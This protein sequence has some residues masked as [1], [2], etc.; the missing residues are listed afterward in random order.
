MIN[1]DVL[2]FFICPPFLSLFKSAHF[3]NAPLLYQL[4]STS[5]LFSL[6]LIFNE[7]SCRR[8]TGGVSS[9]NTDIRQKS[10]QFSLHLD[11][12]LSRGV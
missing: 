5:I 2:V 4:N 7:A 10:Y 1:N 12:F 6:E 11:G 8:Q 9:G 3:I